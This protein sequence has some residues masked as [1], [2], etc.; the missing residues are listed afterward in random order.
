MNATS[1]TTKRPPRESKSATATAFINARIVDP[2]ANRDEPGGLLVRDGLIADIGGTPNFN[3]RPNEIPSPI[4]FAEDTAIRPYDADAVTQ[5]PQV[6]PGYRRG[7]RPARHR[8]AARR[9]QMRPINSRI[10][11]MM[12]ARPRP[13][14]P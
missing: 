14:P 6:A 3:G 7:G 1:S 5:S 13:P 12:S 10:R 2:A 9:R 4:R 8:A 11:T